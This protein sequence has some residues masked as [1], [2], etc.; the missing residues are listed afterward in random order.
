M[1]T[2]NL[3]YKYLAQQMRKLITVLGL[4]LN[5]FWCLFWNINIDKNENDGVLIFI[6]IV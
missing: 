1:S 3:K 2:F 6:N 5:Q 4:Q